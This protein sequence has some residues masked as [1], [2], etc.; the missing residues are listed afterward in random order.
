MK[1]FCV[2]LFTAFILLTTS[3]LTGQEQSASNVMTDVNHKAHFKGGDKKLIDFIADNLEYPK[4][5]MG[6]KIDDKEVISF[7]VEP[8]G[9]LTD[10]TIVKSL[11]KNF[12]EKAIELV[13]MMPKWAPSLVNGVKSRSQVSIPLRFMHDGSVVRAARTNQGTIFGPFN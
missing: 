4:K 6:T 7:F 5:E 8:T 1:T 10:I 11:G 3:S 12:D 13:K 9:K 2:V